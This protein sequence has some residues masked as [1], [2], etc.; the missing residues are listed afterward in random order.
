MAIATAMLDDVPVPAA[1]PPAHGVHISPIGKPTWKPVDFHL[2]SGPFGTIADGNAEFFAVQQVLLPPPKH[3]LNPDLGIGPGAPHSPPYDTELATGVAD[4]AVR[5]KVH[6]ETS[7]FSN[8]AAHP[9]VDE[10]PGARG[11]RAP[12][13]ISSCGPIIRNS[14]FPIHVRGITVHDGKLFDPFLVD[15]SVPPLDE[16]LMQ[17]FNVDG[18]SHFPFFIGENA[19]YGPAKARLRGSYDFK[20]EMIDS[21]GNGWSIECTSRWQAEGE[22]HARRRVKIPIAAKPQRTGANVE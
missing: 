12:R 22:V 3:V 1:R 5:E 21:R 11:R 10:R 17:P 9:G 4:L 15:V 14:L 16:H 8:G 2:F 19:E 18:H 13:P 7:E 20:I 6:F